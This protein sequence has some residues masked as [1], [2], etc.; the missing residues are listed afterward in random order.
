MKR[1][2]SPTASV[3]ATKPGRKRTA[4][5]QVDEKADEGGGQ[6]RRED[7]QHEAAGAGLG[8]DLLG[9]PE[10][11]HPVAPGEREHRADLDEDLELG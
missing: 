7:L 5:I 6:K 1:I 9:Q 2:A 10:K 4:S 11:A 8:E 3:A